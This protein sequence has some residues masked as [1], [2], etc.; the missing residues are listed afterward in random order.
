VLERRGRA[1]RGSSGWKALR[2]GV[3]AT[4]R[5]RSGSVVTP[6]EASASMVSAS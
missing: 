2:H 3:L 5:A 4:Q 1:R 6:A